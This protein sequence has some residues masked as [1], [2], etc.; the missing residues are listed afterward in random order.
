MNAL[1]LSASRSEEWKTTEY[2]QYELTSVSVRGHGDFRAVA[3]H[4]AR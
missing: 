1:R 4:E 2:E 3:N